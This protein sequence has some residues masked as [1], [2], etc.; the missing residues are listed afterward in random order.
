MPAPADSYINCAAACSVAHEQTRNELRAACQEALA[1]GVTC[2]DLA[3]A[4]GRTA[5]FIHN[6]TS[7]DQL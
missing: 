5:A 7:E 1:H 4:T 3:E 2:Q 6:L